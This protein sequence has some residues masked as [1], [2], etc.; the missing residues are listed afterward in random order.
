[1]TN[2]YDIN[3]QLIVLDCIQNAILALA[4]PIPLTTGQLQRT[5]GAGVINQ[6]SDTL[7][8]PSPVRFGSN[9]FEFFASGFPD[10]DAISCHAVSGP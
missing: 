9:A 1:M 8:Y 3:D 6:G 5:I 10:P 7:N 4:D 2:F